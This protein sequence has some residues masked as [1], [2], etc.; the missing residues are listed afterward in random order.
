MSLPSPQPP[1]VGVPPSPEWYTH[2]YVTTQAQTNPTPRPT[3]RTWLLSGLVVA[4]SVVLGALFALFY[5]Y[6]FGLVWTAISL[7][8]ALLPLTLVVPFFLWL[9]RFEAEPW[10]YLV[11]AFLYGALGSTA[12]ALVANSLGG[13]FLMSV[14][15][16]QSAD[17]LTAVLIAPFTEE[18]FKGLFLL[19]MWWFMRHEFNGLTDGIVYAGIVA[20]GFA[21]TENIQYFAGAAIEHGLGGFATTFVV[22]GIISPFLH[23]MFTT[24]TGIGVGLAAVSA[25]RATK[26]VA[27]VLG[28]CGAVLC[29]GLWNLSASAG[30][31]AGLLLG[32][33]CGFVAFVAFV[34]FLVWARRREGRIIGEYLMPYAAT[35][36]LSSDEVGMLSTMKARRRA[37]SWAKHHGGATGTASMRSFQDCASELAL[38]RRRMHR[39]TFDAETLQRERVLLDSMTARRREFAG[40]VSR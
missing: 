36:W 5:G 21:F 14:T 11:T 3:L 9:D 29:H 10:R 6:S 34:I 26:A 22:R 32:L 17:V 23:P 28:W 18:T 8:A 25:S 19:I 35:G 38:L 31:G 4:M 13:A 20:A 27:P 37:R 16:A 39:H 15:S 12:L 1:A 7:L 30:G 2:Q 40:A 33:A 24:L